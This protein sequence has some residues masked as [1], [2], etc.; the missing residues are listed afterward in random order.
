VDRDQFHV[1][2]RELL[3]NI[4]DLA[5]LEKHEAAR[6]FPLA[7]NSNSNGERLR[8]FIF[9]G[10][11]SLKPSGKVNPN[12]LEW[13]YYL[14]LYHRYVE[15][16]KTSDLQ[17]LLMLGDR[18]L[19]RMHGRATDALENTLWN[20]FFAKSQTQGTQS[21][22]SASLDPNQPGQEEGTE[23]QVAQEALDLGKIVQEIIAL[24]S[25]GF[26]SKGIEIDP[27]FSNNLPSI[28]A[29][30][31]ILRQIL[32]GLFNRVLKVWNKGKILVSIIPDVET[33]L[34]ELQTSLD[35]ALFPHESQ[36]ID[37]SPLHYWAERIHAK[38]SVDIEETDYSSKTASAQAQYL[39]EFQK[40]KQAIVLVVDD[41]E[42][43]VRIIQRYLIH[44]NLQVIGV[45]DS[46]RVI[47]IAKKIHPKAILLDVMMPT[48]DGWEILQEIRSTAETRDI[49]VIV[50]SVWDQP[51]FAFS[52][53][54]NGFL[55]KPINEPDL[56]QE[57]VR[58]G[59]LESSGES[60]RSNS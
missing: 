17:K 26:Q 21:P 41:H 20:R 60:P 46:T 14:I 56:I 6:L 48:I 28:Q 53:G 49:A 9:E 12:S 37:Q 4:H 23:F 11:E 38:L 18:Q 47:Q 13:R 2:F 16:T 19:R 33:V 7:G 22:A 24:C 8:Q 51:D 34:L 58:L 27:L 30:R 42:P 45:T 3:A 57:L 29:D 15:G 43:A 35:P 40:V 10:I 39:I 32:I 1:I 44:S 25:P 52:L 50:C 5:V 54:A 36:Q 59:L 55:K 31:I